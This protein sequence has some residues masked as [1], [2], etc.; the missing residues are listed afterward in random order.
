MAEQR[1]RL[2]EIER[3]RF[4]LMYSG[5]HVAVGEVRGV[6]EAAGVDAERD[7]MLDLL[8]RVYLGVPRL[9]ERM[10]RTWTLEIEALLREHGRLSGGGG[11]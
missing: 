4:A 11:A 10:P 5:P 8:E 2:Y 7:R 9:A 1:R 6:Y 3:D